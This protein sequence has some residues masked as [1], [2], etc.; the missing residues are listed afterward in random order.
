MRILHVDTGVSS[1]LIDASETL[2]R[3]LSKS[4]LSL[5]LSS[6]NRLNLRS[7]MLCFL[8]LAS[9]LSRTGKAAGIAAGC[10]GSDVLKDGP[11]GRFEKRSMVEVEMVATATNN[12][13][14]RNARQ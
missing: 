14:G 3:G 2:T 10:C 1:Y 13:H 8:D 5:V 4:S 6:C 7:A 9:P 12:P 11:G